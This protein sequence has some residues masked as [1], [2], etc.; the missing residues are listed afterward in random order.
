VYLGSDYRSRV[1]LDAYTLFQYQMLPCTVLFVDGNHEN[2]DQL[3]SYP[4]KEWN[5]GNVH[6]IR[7][8]I[9]HL[10]RGQVYNICGKKFFTM[11]GA[12]SVDKYNRIEHKSWWKEELP[13]KEECEMAMANLDKHNWEVDYVITHAAPDNILHKISPS[14][15][16]DIITNFLFVVDKDLK[17]KDWYFGHYHIDKDFSYG[18][19]EKYHCLYERII[20]L[21]LND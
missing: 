13:T 20:E 16:H 9:I 5:G 14:F 8:D 7:K 17:F 21:N 4:I 3:N 2:F 11:G 19:G 6:F 18:D 1:D 12:T 15:E 10:M